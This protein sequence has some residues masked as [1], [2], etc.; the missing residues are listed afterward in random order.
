MSDGARLLVVE[1]DPMM[2]DFTVHALISLGY[3]AC[4]AKNAAIALRLL[5]EDRTIRVVIIDL[6]LGKGPGGDQLARAAL[7][8]RPDLRVLLTSGNPLSLQIAGRDMPEGV[9]CLPKPYRRRELAA[10][11]SRLL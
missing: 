8:L 11:L 6:R 7:D 3:S 2:L 4:T 9:E 10:R 1:D 5:D